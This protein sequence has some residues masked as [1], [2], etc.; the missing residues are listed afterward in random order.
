M[1]RFV[2]ASPRSKAD[3]ESLA[4]SIIQAYQPGVLNKGERFEIE[5]FFD[6]ELEALTR[7]S[8]DYQKLSDEIYGYTDSED[9]VCVISSALADDHRKEKF[10]RSTMAHEVGHAVMHVRDYRRMKAFLRSVNKKNH[11]LCVYREEEIILYQNP[12]WQA[13]RFAGAIL[14]PDPAFKS[15]VRRGSNVNDLSKRF[16][17]NPKFVQ[18]RLKALDLRV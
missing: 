14:M 7:V 10:Y 15:A 9:M 3:I 18:S 11:Q 2:P 17:V 1:R 5:R 13:W 8:T 6:C 12:E 4:L 16:G